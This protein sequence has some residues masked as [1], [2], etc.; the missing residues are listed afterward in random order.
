MGEVAKNYGH[1]KFSLQNADQ[2]ISN[3]FV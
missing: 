3:F 2:L 1:E